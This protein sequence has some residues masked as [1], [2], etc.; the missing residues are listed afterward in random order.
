[1]RI[2]RL[3]VEAKLAPGLHLLLP[4]GAFRHCIHVL[5]LSKGAQV[6]LFNGD[7]YDYQAI[8]TDVNRREAQALVTQH[9]KILTE[10]TLDLCLVQGLSKGDHMDITIQKAVEL[11]VRR[12]RPVICHRSQRIPADRLARR[13]AHWCAIAISACEQSG[14]SQLPRIEIPIDFHT[15][16]DHSAASTWR[17]MLDPKSETGFNQAQWNI[18]GALEILIGPEG[19]FTEEELSHAQQ[20][21]IHGLRLGPRIL[22]TETAAIAALSLAQA[23]WGDLL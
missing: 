22:R 12:I 10:S 1:M 20:A 21:G 19:G 3:H 4:E 14:R 6:I 18:A 5:R 16:L 23:R 13:H 7:G 17:I 9:V 8:L 15:W 11:G 2:P